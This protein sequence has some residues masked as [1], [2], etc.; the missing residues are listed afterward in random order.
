M[1]KLANGGEEGGKKSVTSCWRNK[2]MVSYKNNILYITY[3][4]LK[5]EPDEDLK[6][7]LLKKAE[8][9]ESR[10]SIIFDSEKYKVCYQ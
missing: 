9:V 5:A 7:E 1:C 4:I 8:E 6:K 3:S 2:W 10:F